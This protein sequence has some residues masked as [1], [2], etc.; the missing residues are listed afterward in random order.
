MK[1]LK[2]I[3]KLGLAILFTGIAFSAIAADSSKSAKKAL[4][5]KAMKDDHYTFELADNVVRTRVAFHNRFGV[6]L[7]G[8][9]YT[10]KNASGKMP[11]IA[12]AGPFGAVKEQASGLYANQLASRGFVTL[13]FDPSFTGDSGGDVRDVASFDINTD[14]FSAAV[15]Y[16]STYGGVDPEKI[17][18]V[19]IC[20]W[21]GFVLNTA[22]I[23]TRIK[24][25]AAITMYDMHRISANGY[26]DVNDNE[27]SRAA[28]KKALNEIRTNDYAQNK[29]TFA[30][31]NPETLTGDEPQFMKEYWEYY[32]TPRGYHKNSVNSNGGWRST[33]AL[34]LINTPILAYIDEIEN[35]VII[36]HG[37]NA[38][39]RYMGE[40]AFGKLKGDNK[41]LLIVPDANHTD[42]YDNMEKIPF[43]KITDFFKTNLK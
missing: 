42:L 23:D 43:D 11:G 24:A 41:E 30:G 31:G 9:L 38:H 27:A 33:S 12:V 29:V 25:T 36:I 22:A 6:T 35:P 21:G 10:P 17:G 37:E 19:G 39:S 8:D 5:A 16:L 2:K 14:D 13:A 32:K 26:D 7:V 40:T 15:D 1:S 3:S 4:S 28:V 34:S 20:G 18:A